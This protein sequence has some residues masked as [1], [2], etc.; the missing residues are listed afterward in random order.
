M[1]RIAVIAFVSLAAG[2]AV[3]AQDSFDVRYSTYGLPGMVDMPTALSFPDSDLS[4]TVS[5]FGGT[6]RITGSFQVLPRVTGSFRYSRIQ[7]YFGPNDDLF[8]RSFSLHVRLLE[9]TR[10]RPALTLGV[11][12]LIGT[13]VYASEY[14]VA[15]KHLTPR[16]RVTGGLGW[17]RLGSNNGFTNPLGFLSETLETRPS[18]D[19]GRGG[20][21]ELDQFFRGDAAFFGGVEVKATDKLSFAIEYSSDS[22]AREDGPTFDYRSPWNF[23]L[24]YKLREN[25]NV[26]A[27]YLYGS[28]LGVQVTF[29]TNPTEPPYDGG[30]DP[31]P[32]PV[33]PR[34]DVDVAALGW[35]QPD[36][37]A[38][39]VGQLEEVLAAEGVPLHGFSIEGSV[40]RVEIENTRWRANAQAIGRTAR[41]LTGAMPPQV[42]TF[43]IRPVSNG[44]AGSEVTIRRADMEELAFSLDNSW[45]SYARAQ[46]EPTT[47][48]SQPLARVY[49]RFDFG[50]EPYIQPS[51]FDPD[52]PV[53]ADFGIELNGRFEPAP[54]FLVRGAVRQ[55]VFGNL[56][57]SERGSNSVLPRVRT[58][59]NIYERTGPTDLLDLTGS[60]FF[61]PGRDFYGRVTVG[62]LER[63]FGGVSTEVLWKPVDS[64]LG[65][66]V[67]ANY[68]KQRA[69]DQGFGFRD[70]EVATGHASLYYDFNNGF[71]AQVDAGR[72]LAG[73]WGATLTINRTFKNGWKIGAFATLT[74][75]PFEEFG[76]GSFDK[77]LLLTIPLDW[78]RGDPMQDTFS[79]TLR[80]IT[81]DGGARLSIRDRL[82]EKVNQSHEQELRDGWGRFWK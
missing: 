15:T 81:R 55:K 23:G 62:Y 53:R 72:Y 3:E 31:A 66:G 48:P 58:D 64:N 22:Y 50:L 75:V 34:T 30:G 56:D 37:G 20:E 12:D 32:F 57:E 25:V 67:E 13:G 52:A 2:S 59:T 29:T 73:D 4:V 69:F 82:Y 6:S 18:R 35:T 47:T 49:P 9:E 27:A 44:I 40:A 79:Y 28:A 5:D 21:A 54:G 51:L 7:N 19:F 8:D 24:T 1:K 45:S 33:T 60:Y 36:G 11:N 42:D 43:V 14:L 77:G 68:V 76:E 17:G 38:T 61:K 80:P 10:R 65:I 78:A 71:E 26:S 74:D 41:V 39:A 46:I 63:Q 70:Y 16:L